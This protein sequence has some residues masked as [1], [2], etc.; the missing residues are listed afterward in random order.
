MIF[1]EARP[2][3]PP[4]AVLASFIL[5]RQ[6]PFLGNTTVLLAVLSQILFGSTAMSIYQL[7]RFLLCVLRFQINDH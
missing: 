7:F 6:S 2:L 3:R 4:F 5:F 1:E